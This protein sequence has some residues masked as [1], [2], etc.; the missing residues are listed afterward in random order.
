MPDERGPARPRRQAADDRGG[1]KVLTQFLTTGLA[2]KLH[3]VVAPFFVDD[4]RAQRSVGLGSF[5][6]NPDRRPELT[7][8]HQFRDVVRCRCAS[9]TDSARQRRSTPPT[10]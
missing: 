8:V 9:L 7:E 4:S 3:L 2:D 6:W 10:G 1:G 5:P